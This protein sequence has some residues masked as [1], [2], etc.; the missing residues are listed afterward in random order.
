MPKLKSNSS[1]KKRFRVNA[2]GKFKI[3]HSRK[4]HMLT[5]RP[6]RMKRQARG[7]FLV[8]ESD[9]NGLRRMLPNH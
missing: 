3:G 2:A 4:R 5:K 7:M 8:H 9:V 1:A 6:Q